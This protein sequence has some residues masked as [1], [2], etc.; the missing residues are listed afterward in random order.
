MSTSKG[1]KPKGSK[2]KTKTTTPK[3]LKAASRA[4]RS[5]GNAQARSYTLRCPHCRV[6]LQSQGE[7][8]LREGGSSGAATAF[9]GGLAELGEGQ[10]LLERYVCPACRVV[11][12]REPAVEYI[13]IEVPAE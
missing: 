2:A 10:W 6:E 8:E 11:T 5:R 7:I 12:L 13:D 9:L 1:G 4:R 3:R